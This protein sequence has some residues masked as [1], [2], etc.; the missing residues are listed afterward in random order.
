M[1]GGL[2]LRPVLPF[3]GV[4][5]PSGPEIAKKK[6]QKESFGGCFFADFLG[7]SG[8]KG[9]ETPV[10]GRSGL[11]CRKVQAYLIFRRFAL[12]SPKEHGKEGW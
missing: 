10:N 7:I 11:K 9:P 4:S 5:G 3:T 12:H 1:F 2:C 6:S 8:P